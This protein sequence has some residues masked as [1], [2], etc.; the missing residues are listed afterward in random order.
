MTHLWFCGNWLVD[1][2]ERGSVQ[3]FVKDFPAFECGKMSKR[4]S[5]SK[6]EMLCKLLVKTSIKMLEQ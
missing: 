5:R 2:N 6:T 1:T 4:F 3:D